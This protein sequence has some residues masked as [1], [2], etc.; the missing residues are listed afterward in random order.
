MSFS[1]EMVE[2][3]AQ[4]R[5]FLMERMYRHWRVNRT[6]SQ[7]RRILAQMFHLFMS[8]PPSSLLV[9]VADPHSNDV[10]D[11]RG[12]ECAAYVTGELR[13]DIMAAHGNELLRVR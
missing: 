11:G 12:H 3:L 13:C 4:L 5:A 8:E 7:A 6:R 2:D 9:V 1:R 10:F